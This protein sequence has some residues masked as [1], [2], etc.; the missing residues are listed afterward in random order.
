Q[1][2]FQCQGMMNQRE[3]RMPARNFRRNVRQDSERQTVNPDRLAVRD[4]Q[5]K[6]LRARSRCLIWRRKSFADV[7]TFDVPVQSSEFGD[8]PPVV[9]VAAGW[10]IETAWHRE[11]DALHH[12][13]ASYC[14]RARCDSESVMRSSLSSRP[15]RPSSPARAGLAKPSKIYLDRNSVVVLLPLNS[16]TSSRL[17]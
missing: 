13:G 12:K 8:D 2:P 1:S 11:N 5:H 4:L 14:A 9:G 17:R 6:G 16:G 7:E 3:Q 15:G 10:R